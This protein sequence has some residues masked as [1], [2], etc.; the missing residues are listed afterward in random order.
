MKKRRYVIPLLILAA[1][2]LLCEIFSL[3]QDFQRFNNDNVPFLAASRIYIVRE[4]DYPGMRDDPVTQEEAAKGEDVLALL[5]SQ[6]YLLVP[7]WPGPREGGI[8][9]ERLEGCS[10][11]CLAYWDGSL[12]WI[13]GRYTGK[14]RAHIPLFSPSLGEKLDTYCN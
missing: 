2:L 8:V 11:E 6:N 7:L 4:G 10:P 9:I 13:P 12:L 3:R 14:W 1:L 5:R